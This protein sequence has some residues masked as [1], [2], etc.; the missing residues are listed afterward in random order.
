MVVH[1]AF[2]MEDALTKDARFS[3]SDR[4]L[5]IIVLIRHQDMLDVGRMV[6]HI[7]GGVALP[8]E[9]F[10]NKSQREFDHIAVSLAVQEKA[11][12]VS[13]KLR[14]GTSPTRD[15]WAGKDRRWN[16]RNGHAGYASFMKYNIFSL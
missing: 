6:Q 10:E 4:S 16:Y 11:E 13:P 14:K 12:G 8:Q 3:G 1:F 5:P 2:R 15:G 7:H 9:Q